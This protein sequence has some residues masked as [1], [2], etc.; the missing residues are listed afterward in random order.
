[1]TEKSY[2]RQTETESQSGDR[3]Y[4]CYFVSK[5]DESRAKDGKMYGVGVDMYTQKWGERTSRER[6]VADGVFR[7]KLEAELFIQILYN[8]YVTP[9]TLSD[10]VED[11]I[12]KLEN[13]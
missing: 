10:V 5:I 2:I 8:C 3:I 11:N 12:G 1:M 13:F 4:L 9:T 7:T 6:K